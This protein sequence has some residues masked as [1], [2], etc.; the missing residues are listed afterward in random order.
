M[1]FELLKDYN[2]RIIFINEN[3]FIL[4]VNRLQYEQSYRQAYFTFFDSDI[5]NGE[6]YE[7]K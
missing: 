2:N 4:R 7:N 6:T 1:Y 3:E 5:L